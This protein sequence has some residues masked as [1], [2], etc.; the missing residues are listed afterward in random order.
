M[1][2]RTFLLEDSPSKTLLKIAGTAAC[3]ILATMRFSG[4]CVSA[5]DA[6]APDE[7]KSTGGPGPQFEHYA[8][9]AFKPE[10]KDRLPQLVS[11]LNEQGLGSPDRKRKGF[12]NLL[13]EEHWYYVHVHEALQK[14]YLVGYR[15]SKPAQATQWSD[16]FGNA[17]GQD[18]DR[19]T[20]AC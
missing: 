11:L 1:P 7:T 18:L 15:G 10:L 16:G 3:G 5:Y 4:P 19:S 20:C 17:A 9:E 8:F 2:K 13:D 12:Y 14:I 6:D